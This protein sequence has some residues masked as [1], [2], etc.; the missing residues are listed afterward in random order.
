[1][2]FELQHHEQEQIIQSQ[3]DKPVISAFN[4]Y[5]SSASTRV[6]ASDTP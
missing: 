4:M 6:V 5:I 3:I 2:T 1:M